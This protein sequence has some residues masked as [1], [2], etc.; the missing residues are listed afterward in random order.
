[1]KR[2]A[3]LAVVAGALLLAGCS[4][5]EPR[6]SYTPNPDYT[7]PAF[8]TQ[9]PEPSSTPEPAPPSAEAVLIFEAFGDGRATVTWT[10]DG[11]VVQREVDLPFATEL[12][13]GSYTAGVV[14]RMSGAVGCRLTSDGT[15][16]DEKPIQEGQLYAECVSKG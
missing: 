12:D 11:T 14:Q 2:L 7:S 5:A 16:I 6:S 9:A 13:P 15:I 4:A 10:S 3:P 1:M 8:T